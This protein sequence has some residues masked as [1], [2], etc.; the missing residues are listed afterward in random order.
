M[1]QLVAMPHTWLMTNYYIISTCCNVSYMVGNRLLRHFNQ[2]DTLSTGYRTSCCVLL[3]VP[4]L[5]G[6][7]LDWSKQ[8]VNQSDVYGHIDFYFKPFHIL[9]WPVSYYVRPIF[10]IILAVLWIRPSKPTSCPLAS[11]IPTNQSTRWFDTSTPLDQLSFGFDPP[12]RLMASEWVDY[13][14]WLV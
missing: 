7:I 10:C 1:F 14:A 12:C 11:T 3:A 9:G 13:F 5:G 8:H 2:L 4:I 6:W